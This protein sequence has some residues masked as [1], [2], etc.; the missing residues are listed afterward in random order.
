MCSLEG[1]KKL[2]CGND[3]SKESF[4]IGWER[5]LYK[6]M[7]AWML[8]HKS[9]WKQK[10]KKADNNDHL[11]HQLLPS[12]LLQYGKSCFDA[13]NVSEPMYRMY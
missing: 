8:T 1:L 6:R 7:A 10:Q 11:E 13:A 9:K 5:A 3:N 4:K 12:P 2:F